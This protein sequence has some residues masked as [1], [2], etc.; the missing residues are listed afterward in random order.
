MAEKNGVIYMW[1]H[2]DNEAPSW[3]VPQ[4]EGL[5]TWRYHCDGYSQHEIC[6]HIQVI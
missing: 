5:D 3:E 4:V 6:A 2:I 1:H